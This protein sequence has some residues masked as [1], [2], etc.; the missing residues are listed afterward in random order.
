MWN[1]NPS[2]IDHQGLRTGDS[3]DSQR[4]SRQNEEH[5]KTRKT[6]EKRSGALSAQSD[7]VVNDNASIISRGLVGEHHRTNSEEA[8][9]AENHRPSRIIVGQ[10]MPAA[11]IQPN[12]APLDAARTAQA[13]RPYHRLSKTRLIAAATRFI[14]KST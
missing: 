1:P 5:R 9:G 8:A 13:R 3:A 12:A 14:M 4:N 10:L 11:L 6:P 7:E 2:C